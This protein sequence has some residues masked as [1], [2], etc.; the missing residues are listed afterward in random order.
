MILERPKSAIFTSRKVP[1]LRQKAEEK[2]RSADAERAPRRGGGSSMLEPI[3]MFSG[4]SGAAE[5]RSVCGASAMSAEAPGER[6]SGHD[7]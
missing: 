4:L 7:G 3:K 6:T 5:R 1:V 2:P